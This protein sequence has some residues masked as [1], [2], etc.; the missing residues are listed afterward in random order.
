MLT[1][2]DYNFILTQFPIISERIQ[3]TIK[4]REENEAR[5][6]VEQAALEAAKKAEEEKE[7]LAKLERAALARAERG[8]RPRSG[9][10]ES[11]TSLASSI[12]TRDHRASS[13]PSGIQ[14][15]APVMSS[16]SFNAPTS[17]KSMKKL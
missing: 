12:L 11:I 1:K 8:S 10:L 13:K 5:K 15:P 6:K 4:E 7:A 3:R 2:D 9:I 17:S 16:R 14:T